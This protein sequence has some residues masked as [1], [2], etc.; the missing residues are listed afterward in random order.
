MFEA[1]TRAIRDRSCMNLVR[2]SKRIILPRQGIWGHSLFEIMGFLHP[3][4]SMY[5]ASL[6]S[7]VFSKIVLAGGISIKKEMEYGVWWVQSECRR[8]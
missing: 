7:S 8:V 5:N 3:A 2:K 4:E 1:S 6:L